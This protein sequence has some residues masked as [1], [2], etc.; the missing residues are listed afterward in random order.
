MKISDIMT[1]NIKYLSNKDSLLSGRQLMK[2]NQ[3][4]HIPIVDHET[5]DFIGILCQKL[6]LAEALKTI[7]KVGLDE[8]EHVES[9]TKIGE[10]LPETTVV[11]TPDTSLLDAARTFLD[12]KNGC[13]P[14]VE[15]RKIVGLITA[16]D[17]VKLA[18]YFLEQNYDIKK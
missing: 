11:V 17:L 2:E 13:V 8:L 12:D 14:V 15:S 5:E 18:I 7:D 9:Q 3:I 10:V 6:V 16:N 4:R 1:T